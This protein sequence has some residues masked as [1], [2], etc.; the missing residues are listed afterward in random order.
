LIA[1]SEKLGCTFIELFENQS[2]IAMRKSL[3]MIESLND[4]IDTLLQPRGKP[5]FDTIIH[6]NK[7]RFIYCWNR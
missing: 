3:T 7:R 5:S 4:A 6:L 1:E 2:F